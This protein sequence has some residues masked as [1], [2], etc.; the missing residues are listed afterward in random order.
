[1]T[2][3]QLGIISGLLVVVLTAIWPVL[4]QLEG[5]HSKDPTR[6]NAGISE[7]NPEKSGVSDG[8]GQSPP[9][10]TWN[11]PAPA[12]GEPQPGVSPE[13]EGEKETGSSDPLLKE[14]LDLS[15]RS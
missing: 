1:M 3:E 7:K 5:P 10:S 6:I 9:Q 13:T 15:R 8:E 14:P 4:S 2:Q 12:T 11:T